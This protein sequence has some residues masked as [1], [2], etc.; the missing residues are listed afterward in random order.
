M[1]FFRYY[2]LLFVIYYGTSLGA[3]DVKWQVTMPVSGLS[4][5]NVTVAS[6]CSAAVLTQDNLYWYSA[7]GVLQA[8]VDLA[9]EFGASSGYYSLLF[10]GEDSI[11]LTDN[12]W[13]FT[14]QSKLIV[15]SFSDGSV[16]HTVI[17]GSTVDNDNLN[18]PPSSYL[19]VVNGTTLTIYSFPDVSGSS[20]D[21]GLSM[22]PNNAVVIPSSYQ[23]NVDVIL[24]TSNDLVEWTQALP[25]TYNPATSPRFFRVRAES[26][27]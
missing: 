2:L 20:S 7:S 10:V 8:T 24:E 18:L 26:A 1:N 5:D 25:G 22:V 14:N 3:I 21:S 12:N 27:E 16:S 17:I 19:P 4:G 15:C 11:M 6:D 13:Q 23:G 9:S